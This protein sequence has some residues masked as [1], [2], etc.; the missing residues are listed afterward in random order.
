[1]LFISVLQLQ[2]AV[3]HDSFFEPEIEKTAKALRKARREE[4]REMA[5]HRENDANRPPPTVPIRDHRYGNDHRYREND[6][7]P[8]IS[9]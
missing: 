9:S 3:S 2:K 5:E 8:T 4:L 6:A 7:M 1:M